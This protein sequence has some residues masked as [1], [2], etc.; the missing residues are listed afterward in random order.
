MGLPIYESKTAHHKFAPL[1]KDDMLQFKGL[2]DTGRSAMVQGCLNGVQEFARWPHM[3][4][5]A[6]ITQKLIGMG[7]QFQSSAIRMQQFLSARE[8]QNAEPVARRV[9]QRAY[10]VDRRLSE[11]PL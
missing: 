2:P 9:I 5:A 1:L 8:Q 7:Y 10:F 4:S 3:D 11:L 6:W